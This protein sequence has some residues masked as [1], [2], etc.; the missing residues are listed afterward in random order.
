MYKTLQ[1]NASV[2][3][4]NANKFSSNKVIKTQMYRHK[5]IENT[6]LIEASIKLKLFNCS[7]LNKITCIDVSQKLFL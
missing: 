7:W 3:Q 2:L 5:V 4:F 6:K 1:L